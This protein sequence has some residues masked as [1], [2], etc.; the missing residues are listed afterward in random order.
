[1]C[2]Q[3]ANFIRLQPWLLLSQDPGNLEAD[4]QVGAKTGFA[5]LWWVALVTLIC[6]TSFQCLSGRLGLVTGKDLARHCGERWP[7]VTCWFLWVM[8]ELAIVAV[9]IQETIGSAQALFMLSNGQIPLWAGT[10]SDVACIGAAP[11]HASG[12]CTW[13]AA[14]CTSIRV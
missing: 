11:F 2:I 14:L 3:R 13:R 5:L 12:K 1:M 9:D 4:I 7:R 6:G 10:V 8:L